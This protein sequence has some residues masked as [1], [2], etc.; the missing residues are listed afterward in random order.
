ML[1][2]IADT[3]ARVLNLE[4]QLRA[5]CDRL[6]ET[7]KDLASAKTLISSKNAQVTRLEAENLRLKMERTD[8]E[9]AVQVDGL[10][11]EV[12]QKDRLKIDLERA[13]AAL[14]DSE[15][16]TLRRAAGLDQKIVTLQNTLVSMQKAR[17]LAQATQEAAEQARVDAVREMVNSSD[18]VQKLEERAKAFESLAQMVKKLEDTIAKFPP[19]ILKSSK[20]LQAIAAITKKSEQKTK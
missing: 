7:E 4:V 9:L 19:A 20:E 1:P 16:L 6:L 5:A 18:K 2:D 17:D 11:R 15:I 3:A 12:G 14:K 10:R 13:N 8:K